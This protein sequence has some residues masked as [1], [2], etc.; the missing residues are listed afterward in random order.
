MMIEKQ[1]QEIA[2]LQASLSESR[3]SRDKA[4]AIAMSKLFDHIDKLEVEIIKNKIAKVNESLKKAKTSNTKA[5][6]PVQLLLFN[7][8]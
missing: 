6:C 8:Q 2:S 7:L 1:L 3:S 5:N 4:I